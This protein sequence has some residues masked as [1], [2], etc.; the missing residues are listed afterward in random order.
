M[1]SEHSCAAVVSEITVLPNGRKQICNFLHPFAKFETIFIKNCFEVPQNS[2]K[3][4]MLGVPQLT[5]F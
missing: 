1:L 3:C 4:P 5:D 2:Q